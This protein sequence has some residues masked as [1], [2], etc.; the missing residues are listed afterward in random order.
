MVGKTVLMGLFSIFV[1]GFTC[2]ITRVV[3]Y[4]V[5]KDGSQFNFCFFS[6]ESIRANSAGNRPSI[7]VS[8]IFF[9]LE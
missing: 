3:T 5:F 7:A 8:L 1:G 4:K 2:Y 6:S 9:F